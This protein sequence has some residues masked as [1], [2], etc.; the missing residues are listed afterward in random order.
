MNPFNSARRDLLRVGSLGM[1]G[2]ALPAVSFAA[3]AAEHGF[4]RASPPT[5]A[6]VQRPPVRR[7]R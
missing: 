6:I 4:R 5:T 7:K 2:A 3:E 1:A